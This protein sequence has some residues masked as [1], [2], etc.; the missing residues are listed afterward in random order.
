MALNNK[1]NIFTHTHARTNTHTDD[2]IQTKNSFRL[3]AKFCQ[4]RKN[5]TYTS[6]E[7]SVQLMKSYP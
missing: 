5:E 7:N 1:N 6:D 4:H 2:R 3:Q